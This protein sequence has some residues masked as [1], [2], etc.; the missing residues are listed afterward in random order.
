MRWIRAALVAG[1]VVFGGCN[2]DG[3]FGP[4]ELPMDDEE[5]GMMTCV[6]DGSVSGT[7]EAEVG[8]H[9]VLVA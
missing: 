8:S 4:R 1:A 9:T 6:R 3:L 2:A 7:V 5:D